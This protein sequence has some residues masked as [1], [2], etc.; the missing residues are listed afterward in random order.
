MVLSSFFFSSLAY[1]GNASSYNNKQLGVNLK[2]I[3]YNKQ[4][5]T[6]DAQNNIWY[7]EPNLQPA[8]TISVPTKPQDGMPADF[9]GYGLIRIRAYHSSDMIYKDILGELKQDV[10]IKELKKKTINRKKALVFNAV[11]ESSSAEALVFG[12]KYVINIEMAW[13][14]NKNDVF[15]TI[16]KSIKF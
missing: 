11:G 8:W 16:L 4:Q 9:D 10:E 3:E 6:V 2:Y 13:E 12:K 14:N 5:P 7:Y 1:A 15:Q